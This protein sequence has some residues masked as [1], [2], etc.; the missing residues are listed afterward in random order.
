MKDYD[1]AEEYLEKAKKLNPKQFELNFLFGLLAD[2][3]GNKDKALNCY[4]KE[5]KINP[6]S[7]K[8][9]YNLAVQLIKDG[10][11]SDA[12]KY[13][14]RVI[15]L[16]PR[17]NFPYFMAARCIYEDKIKLKEARR[18]C[19][20]GLKVG[21]RDKYTVYGYLLLSDIYHR[22]GQDELAQKSFDKGTALKEQ[23]GR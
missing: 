22:L 6:K 18:L 15:N 21:T 19:E 3:T 13:F 16:K 20:I 14:K 7:S 17:F 10:N 5:I 9:L 11:K 1:K 23:L 8:A 4:K 2:K 12:E